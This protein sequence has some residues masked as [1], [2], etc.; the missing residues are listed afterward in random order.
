MRAGSSRSGAF[1]ITGGTGTTVKVG[2]CRVPMISAPTGT[3]AN[4]GAITLGTALDT[5][6]ADCYLF[7]PAG[8]IAAGVPAAASW[9][10]AQMSSATVGTVFN[11]TYTSGDV[12]VPASPTPFVSTG[13]G[14][15][16]GDTAEEQAAIFTL[17]VLNAGALIDLRFYIKNNNTAG[18]KT[19]R[20][21]LNGAAGSLLTA[22]AQTTV[23]D[24]RLS[25]EIFNI[26]QAKQRLNTVNLGSTT[27]NMSGPGNVQVD[28]SAITDVR[29]TVQKAVA[30]DWVI[31]E[32]GNATFIQ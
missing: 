8:A 4:N 30:T 27:I 26:T 10:Y 17:P 18:T 15:F 5:T 28:T 11:N 12:T 6:Y 1:N 13:P 24:S 31:L 9:L 25:I 21:R 22:S 20:A 16:T 29:F 2:T 3:M 7:L 14:A 23:T 19:G 32:F